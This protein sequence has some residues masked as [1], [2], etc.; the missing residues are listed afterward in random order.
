MFLQVTTN[1]KPGVAVAF[2]FEFIISFLLIVVVLYR[3]VKKNL[4]KFTATF[5]AILI[6]VFITFEAPYSG[7]SMN[8]ARSF[9]SCNCFR[10]ME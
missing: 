6:A 10:A 2:L 7:M 8:P 9:S 4:S 5:V 3:N 1:P